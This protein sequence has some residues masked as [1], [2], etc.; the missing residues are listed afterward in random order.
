MYVLHLKCIHNIIVQ[1]SKHMKKEKRKKMDLCHAIHGAPMYLDFLSHS[2]IRTL[3]V[4]QF[5]A[6]K[7]WFNVKPKVEKSMPSNIIF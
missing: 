6:E 4:M 1:Y 5:K 2:L 7:N 3:F